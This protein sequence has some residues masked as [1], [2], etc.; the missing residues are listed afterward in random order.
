MPPVS[1][2]PSRAVVVTAAGSGLGHDIALGFAAKGY[3]VFG[4]AASSA[5]AEEVKKSSRGRVS[6]TVC[7][8]VDGVQAWAGVISDALGNAGIDILVNNTVD[9]TPA[10]IEAHSLDA[11]RHEFEVNVFGVVSGYQCLFTC[12]ENGTWADRPGQFVDGRPATTIQWSV[13][14]IEGCHRGAFSR[15]PRGVETLR[16]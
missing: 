12:T 13:R 7:R 5:E 14:C 3:I 2:R 6:L 9:F 4:T 11:V 16:D 8:T 15:V 10:P 1:L